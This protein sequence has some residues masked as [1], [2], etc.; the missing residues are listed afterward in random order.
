MGIETRELS[1]DTGVVLFDSASETVFGPIFEAPV[2]TVEQFVK[3]CTPDVLA[4]RDGELAERW[5]AFQEEYKCFECGGGSIER[6][7]LTY[8]TCCFGFF[9]GE[10]EG[11]E[12]TDGTTKFGHKC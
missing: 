5:E 4:D 11:E 10:H 2:E 8:Q 1:H 12:W 3:H 7:D 9:C 6:S